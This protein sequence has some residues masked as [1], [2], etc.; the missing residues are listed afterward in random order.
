MV[1]V[2]SENDEIKL[3]AGPK[4]ILKSNDVCFYMSITK[5]ENS[6]LLI[7]ASEKEQIPEEDLTLTG[8]FVKKFSFRRPSFSNRSNTNNQVDQTKSLLGFYLF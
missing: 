5:E 2:Q 3:N 7:E 6:S 8:N 4:Y 1:G